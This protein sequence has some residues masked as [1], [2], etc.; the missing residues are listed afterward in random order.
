MTRRTVSPN[1]LIFEKDKIISS[2]FPTEKRATAAAL[3]S[4]H[5]FD[6]KIVGFFVRGTYCSTANPNNKERP[7]YVNHSKA[8]N[9]ILIFLSLFLSED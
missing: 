5:R 8:G 3:A 9:K 2:E 4:S 7:T 1:P 6:N